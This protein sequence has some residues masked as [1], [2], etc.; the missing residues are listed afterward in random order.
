MT[1]FLLIIIL[2]LS[3]HNL[4]QNQTIMATQEQLAQELRDIKTQNDKARAEVLQKIADLEAAIANA[5]NTTTEVDEALAALKA[6]VQTDD[7]IVP[8]APPQ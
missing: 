5:G 3:I 1:I 7:D 4:I 2:I 6:S 8:D